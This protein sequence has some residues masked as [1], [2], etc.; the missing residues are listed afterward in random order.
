VTT[1]V[2]RVQGK[3][4]DVDRCLTWLP[5]DKVER[6]WRVGDRRYG[7]RISVESGFNLVLAEGSDGEQVLR[8]ALIVLETIAAKIG[9]LRRDGAESELDLS[10]MVSGDAPKSVHIPIDLLGKLHEFN[11]SLAVSAFPCSD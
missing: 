9:E 7:G 6:T 5:K 2:L 1:A 10:L 3:M 11:V 8:D 4:V